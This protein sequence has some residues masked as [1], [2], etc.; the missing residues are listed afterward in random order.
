M[1]Q[2]YLYLVVIA[3][4]CIVLLLSHYTSKIR[5]LE[6]KLKEKS[7]ELTSMPPR[8]IEQSAKPI[9]LRS[10]R[11]VDINSKM[12]TYEKQVMRRELLEEAGK[13]IEIITERINPVFATNPDHQKIT[14]RLIIF[15]SEK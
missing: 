12:L 11:I 5:K 7:K 8:F 6:K 4:T 13:F 15:K 14:M 2:E 10:E 9:V 3:G 1:W